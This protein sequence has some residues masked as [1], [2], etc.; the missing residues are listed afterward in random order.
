MSE[1]EVLMAVGEPY[2]KVTDSK[3]VREWHYARSNGVILVVQFNAKGKVLKAGGRATKATKFYG[4]KKPAKTT[5]D[6]TGD[7]TKN[8]TPVDD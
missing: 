8:G 4:G 6:T 5:D 1:D 7:K 3:G 2:E